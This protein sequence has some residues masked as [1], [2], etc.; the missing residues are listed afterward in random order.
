VQPSDTAPTEKSSRTCIQKKDGKMF[1]TSPRVKAQ[2]S[3]KQLPAFPYRSGK[4]TLN[5]PEPKSK[6]GTGGS[7]SSSKELPAFPYRSGKIV[8]KNSPKSMAGG[9]SKKASPT[10]LDDVDVFRFDAED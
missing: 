7:Q 10:W 4:I 8:L 6:S 3:D 9:R 5:S 1:F 2:A